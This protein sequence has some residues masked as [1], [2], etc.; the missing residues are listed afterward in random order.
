MSKTV[1]KK[2]RLLITVVVSAPVLVLWFEIRDAELLIVLPVKHIDYE[3]QC[4]PSQAN[5]LCAQVLLKL[6]NGSL[7]KKM[8]YHDIYESKLRS[9]TFKL[10]NI[11][12]NITA[13][14]A[15]KR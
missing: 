14:Q 15:R 3:H 13:Q 12:S 2:I 8:E 7:Y 4:F 1:T 9:S 6:T 10:H 5:N 11:H